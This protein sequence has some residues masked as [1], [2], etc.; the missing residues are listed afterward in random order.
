MAQGREDD[1]E[2][3][4]TIHQFAAGATGP[5]A[6]RTPPPTGL[7][8]DSDDT[9]WPPSDHTDSPRTKSLS[10]SSSAARDSN[11]GSLPRSTDLDAQLVKGSGPAPGE[12]LFD[13]YLVERKLGEGGMG[14]VWLVRHL[15]FDSPRALKLIVSGIALDEQTRAR[16]KREARIMD[17]LNH[18]NVVRVYN[19][20]LG[21]E[22]AF[23]EMEYV[24]GHSL[25]TVLNPG[26]PLPL[27]EV[28]QLVEQLCDVLQAANDQGIIHRDLKPSNLIVAD[29]RNPGQKMLKLLDFGIA[30]IRSGEAEDAITRTGLF[31]GTP[32]Y[33]SP[34]QIQGGKVDS[35]SDLYSLG[36]LL[37]EM[38]TG[39]RPFSGSL[40]ALICCHTTVPPPPFR[41][42]NPNVELPEALEQVVMACLAKSPDDRPQS[43]RQLAEMFHRALGSEVPFHFASDHRGGCVTGGNVPLTSTWPLGIDTSRALD[44]T[45]RGEGEPSRTAFPATVVDPGRAPGKPVSR[46]LLLGLAASLLVVAGLAAVLAGFSWGSRHGGPL[47]PVPTP[48]KTGPVVNRPAPF[49]PGNARIKTQLERW[50]LKGLEPDRAEGTTDGWP[51]VLVSARPDQIRYRRAAQGIYLPNGYSPGDPDPV[52][53]K[54]RRLVRG[55]G[56][57]FIRIHGS[58][59][60]MGDFK[61]LSGSEDPTR[62]AH[63]V[64]LSSYYLQEKEVTNGEL[65]RFLLDTTGLSSCPEWKLVYDQLKQAVGPEE[66]RRHPAVAVHHHVARVFAESRGGRLPTE[67]QWEYAA[68]SEGRP[69][70]KVWQHGKEREVPVDQLANLHSIGASAVFTTRGG[71]YP[72]DATAQGVFDLAGNVREMCRDEWL[73]YSLSG[74]GLDPEFPPDPSKPKTRIVIRGGSYMSDPLRGNATDRDEPMELS[75]T[76]NDIGF[77]LVIECPEETVTSAE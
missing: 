6:E 8:S 77:R 55:D 21:K 26:V 52:D 4:M 70:Y 45:E 17:R 62:P 43:P 50:K 53:G 57:V 69:I 54:P 56:V 23:I 9:R 18:P 7:D 16:F 67:A 49:D 42:I 28:V 38:L 29:G 22:T 15:E 5:V 74:P 68:R 59:F 14:T 2:E 35:R 73:D 61:G 3:R 1:F 63:P 71:M 48:G 66:A 44:D 65:E 25:N 36:V 72:D 37:Y 24:P 46:V 33:S 27:S 40:T 13:R 60:E 10:G 58:Q 11:S 47:A 39:Y 20:S 31:L 30:K 34:E 75:N 19:A 12:V 64:T 51:N 76:A 32:V 41:A